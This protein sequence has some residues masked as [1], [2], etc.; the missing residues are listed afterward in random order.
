MI[1]TIE[2]YIYGA[3]LPVFFVISLIIRVFLPWDSVFTSLP[4]NFPKIVSFG[5]NDP[6]YHMRLVELTVRHFPHR[7]MFDPL[8]EFPY[9]THIH[10][11]PLMDQIIAAI[12]LIVGFGHGMFLRPSS[13]RTKLFFLKN[14]I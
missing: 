6:W 3:L 9:G 11:G 7:L 10:F 4:P 2:K 12:S 14:L 13:L 1:D 5:G 8:T